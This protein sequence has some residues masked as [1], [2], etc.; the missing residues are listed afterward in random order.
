MQSEKR[1]KIRG[2][3]FP[4]RLLALRSS[5]HR[6]IQQIG[7]QQKYHSAIPLSAPLCVQAPMDLNLS[8]SSLISRSAWEPHHAGAHCCLHLLHE[9]QLQ[10]V[11]VDICDPAVARS[12]RLAG[13]CGLEL[14]QHLVGGF[15]QVQEV[16][17][18]HL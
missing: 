15:V 14:A 8:A 10:V 4:E 17:Q 18:L 5:V 2:Q 7:I 16:V 11:H 6:T 1:T 3:H 12:T 9:I 13:N